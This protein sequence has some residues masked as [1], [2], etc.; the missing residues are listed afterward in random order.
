MPLLYDLY[1]CKFK[2]WNIFLNA[3]IKGDFIVI[4]EAQS[5]SKE[6]VHKILIIDD[7]T[8]NTLLLEKMLKISGYKDIKVSTDPREATKLC[9]TYTPDLLLLDLR[10][11]YLDGFEVINELDAANL[12]TMPIIMISAENDKTYHVKALQLGVK[13]F[14]TKPFNFAEILQKIKEIL[15][16]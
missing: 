6:T 16:S 14:I 7:N 10:M 13:D 15:S 9:Q 11:P 8:S 4:S 1:Y 2:T 5:V 3:N 12:N